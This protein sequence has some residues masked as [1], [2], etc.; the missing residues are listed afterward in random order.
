[1]RWQF[2]TSTVAQ[3]TGASLRQVDY[4]TRRGLVRPS[5]QAGRGKGSRR[6]YTFKDL[7]AVQA[8]HELRER[9]CSLQ[10]VRTAVDYLKKHYPSERDLL[11][12]VTLLTDGNH[13]Y[14]LTD[15]Q[16]VMEVVTRQHVWSLALGQMIVELQQ[17]VESLP[18]KR[19]ERV[20][21]D[22][23]GY[24]LVVIRDTESDTYTVQCKELPGAIEQGETAKEAIENGKEAIRS[25]L[26]FM[27][28]QRA[29]RVGRAEAV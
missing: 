28:K 19:I 16:E 18:T 1:M 2:S 8:I 25:A 7:V 21:I 9:G 5:A 11:A 17:K 22:G 29:G 14:I 13:V 26:T 20:T 4:W 12:K 24:H 23:R 3:V 6:R 10:K 15:E 27:A